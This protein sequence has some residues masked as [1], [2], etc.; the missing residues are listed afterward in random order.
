MSDERFELFSAMC[1]IYN[2]LM[3]RVVPLYEAG[4]A[5]DAEAITEIGFAHME[6]RNKRLGETVGLD[7]EKCKELLAM[8]EMYG[9]DAM[10]RALEEEH[11]DQAR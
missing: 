9:D 4:L 8:R 1:D 6:Y 10:V 11:G 5:N 2:D 3:D 7:M